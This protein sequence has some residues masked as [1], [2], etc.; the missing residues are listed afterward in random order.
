MLF[1]HVT[2]EIPVCRWGMSIDL[3]IVL[4]IWSRT[5][6]VPAFGDMLRPVD[7]GQIMRIAR[8]IVPKVRGP[9]INIIVRTQVLVA[10][11]NIAIGPD[12]IGRECVR[13]VLRY[14]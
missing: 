13:Y 7:N 5:C 14:T 12:F 1:I 4:A 11:L 10:T 8:M 3:E 2:L 6:E 9:P